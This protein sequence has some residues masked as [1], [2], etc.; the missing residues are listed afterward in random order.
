VLLPMVVHFVSGAQFH[1]GFLVLCLIVVWIIFWMKFH[2]GC[3]IPF[4]FAAL[5]SAELISF[6]L[7]HCSTAGYVLYLLMWSHLSPSRED[8]PESNL[9]AQLYQLE[10]VNAL[11]VHRILILI[12]H[13][14]VALDLGEIICAKTIVVIRDVSLLFVDAHL[15]LLA[16]NVLSLHCGLLLAGSD[17]V[18]QRDAADSWQPC[19]HFSCGSEYPPQ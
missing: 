10:A 9:V 14:L 4:G 8:R 13:F 11:V 6:S 18:V 1:D 2:V 19:A 7:A 5:Y 16:E 12:I 3:W 17:A 15:D